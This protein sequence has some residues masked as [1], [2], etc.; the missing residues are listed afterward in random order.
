MLGWLELWWLGV[1]I[2]PTTIPVVVV[3]GHTGHS[4]VHCPVRATL[5]DHWGLELLTVE[6]VCPLAAPDIP[7]AH[8]TVR[9]ILM[10]Q[11]NFCAADYAAVSVV[12]HWAKLTVAL[13]SHRTV[14]WYTGQSDEF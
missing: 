9:C 2:A 1:F 8:W 7:V 6:V 13:L 12:D 14:R 4:T 5:A 11:T 10:L 3:D